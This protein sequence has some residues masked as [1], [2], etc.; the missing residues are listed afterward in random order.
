M[1]VSTIHWSAQWLD[2]GKRE[3]TVLIAGRNSMFKAFSE[4]LLYENSIIH[5][6]A[7]WTKVQGG[8]VMTTS[9]A[10]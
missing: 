1:K 4:G 2:P 7:S 8:A 5:D 10:G 9:K 6:S 3:R